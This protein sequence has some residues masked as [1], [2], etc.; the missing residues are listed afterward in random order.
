MIVTAPRKRVRAK[1]VCT[2]ILGV[3]A[4][5]AAGFGAGWT[6]HH[7]RPHALE[8][9]GDFSSMLGKDVS[10]VVFA[11][12]P[13]SYCA[14]LRR[15]LESSELDHSWRSLSASPE[16]KA[17]MARHHIDR[18][19][20]LVTAHRIYAGWDPELANRVRAGAGER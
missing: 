12:E 11:D 4:S 10:V 2:L 16:I 1:G 18:I 14:P 20:V 13:C 7:G 8:V 5:M 9:G 3:A 17:L 6:M 19:P 15:D